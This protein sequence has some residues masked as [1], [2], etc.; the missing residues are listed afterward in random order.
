MGSTTDGKTG[1]SGGTKLESTVH[2]EARPL[3]WPRPRPQQTPSSWPASSACHLS[4][5]NRPAGLPP[6]ACQGPVQPAIQLVP[7]DI[8]AIG[9]CPPAGLPQTMTI[10]PAPAEPMQRPPAGSSHLDSWS[11]LPTTPL[12]PAT[13][14]Q[15]RVAHR[16]ILGERPPAEPTTDNDHR[17]CPSR[18][19]PAPSSWL[20]PPGQLVQSAHHAVGP[21]DRI[22]VAGGPQDYPW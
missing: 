10:G 12:A 15:L 17:P 22:P 21:S 14:F 11:S 4:H 19:N 16:I 3:P 5:D 9:E 20:E 6:A 18:A 2:D 13:A 1:D 7:V 8:L